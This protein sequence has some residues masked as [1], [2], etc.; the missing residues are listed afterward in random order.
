M[1][2][3][4]NG[5]KLRGDASA[6]VVVDFTIHGLDGSTLKQ[7][8]DGQLA[9]V[10]GD[11]YTASAI[12]VVKVI[13][14]VNTDSVARTINLFLLPSGGT[15]RRILAKDFS[16]GIGY[17]LLYDGIKVTVLN[18]TGGV[19]TSYVAHAASHI[20]GTDDIQD[21]TAAQKGVAT[22]AQITKLDGIEVLADVTDNTN[23]TAAGAAMAA[24]N[25]GDNKLVRGDG[26]VEG[27]QESTILVSDA[28]EMTNPSQP[29]F[30]AI[31]NTQQVDITGDGTLYSITGAFWTEIFDQGNDFS[32]GTFTAPVTGKYKLSA[33][34]KFSGL[35]SAHVNA[36]LS[37][38]TS[39]RGYLLWINPFACGY[40]AGGILGIS[41]NVLADMDA[42]DTAYCR[43]LVY[44]GTKVVD[45]DVNNYFG[46]TLIC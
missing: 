19:V 24:A 18:P 10:T 36:Q 34:F 14:F 12:V 30:S 5:D 45:V 17:S 27:V 46:A 29:A 23:V 33:V 16:L 9:D 20:D 43:V 39:N 44:S 40:T 15:A 38:T 25:I 1:L 21:A 41:L 37:I 7:L 11:I 31:V 2:I 8:A 26:G 35:L 32:N 22:S 13:T 42:N 6:A 3:L 28:G 4:D